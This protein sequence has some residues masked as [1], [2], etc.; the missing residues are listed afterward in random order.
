MTRRLLIGFG[1]IVVLFLGSLRFF[2]PP[3]QAGADVPAAPV[4]SGKPV[5]ITAKE[6]VGV[7]LEKPE[8]R[9]LGSRA[10]VV[11]KEMKNEPHQYTKERFGGG[12]VWVPV[13]AITLLVELEPLQREK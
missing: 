10:F 7:T 4:L 9:Q 11:G 13:D 3:A 8:V 12:M 6:G 1:L 2:F 5:L